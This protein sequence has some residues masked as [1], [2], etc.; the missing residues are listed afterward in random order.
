M[1]MIS[2]SVMA[3][4]LSS[5]TIWGDTISTIGTDQ[6]Y[7]YSQHGTYDYISGVEV[8]TTDPMRPSSWGCTALGADLG[9]C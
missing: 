6:G 1:I 7:D 3:D 9:N 2:S 8:P 4:N 5:S